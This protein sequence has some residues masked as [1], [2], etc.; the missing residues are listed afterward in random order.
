[1]REKSI[2]ICI[3]GLPGS[4]K[5]HY[6]NQE[7]SKTGGIV[8]DDISGL[9]QLKSAF[10]DNEYIYI[11]DPHFCISQLRDNAAKMILSL[12]ENIEIKWVYFENSVEKCLNNVKHRKDSRSV[13]PTIMIYTKIY[14][15]PT[16]AKKIWQK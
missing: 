11:T 10:V 16:D 15:P 14:D 2:I 5:T 13:E 8:I 7:C 1:M 3:V 9:G 4:G 6:A 12:G